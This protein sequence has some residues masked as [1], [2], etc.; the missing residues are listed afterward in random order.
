MQ[1]SQFLRLQ[2]QQLRNNNKSINNLDGLF[3]DCYTNFMDKFTYVFSRPNGRIFY[4]DE[5]QAD[6]MMFGR[7]TWEANDVKYEGRIP[8]DEF[9]KLVT[10]SQFAI[11]R[12]T[13]IG[14]MQPDQESKELADRAEKEE[15][16]KQAVL[17]KVKEIGDKGEPRDF[18]I[19]TQT[20]QLQTNSRVTSMVK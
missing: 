1:V 4:Y 16:F 5:K 15:A 2:Q 7:N 9:T 13:D 10:T 12:A 20:G 18:S 19:L 8:T 14:Q 3:F 6:R 11:K 17:D